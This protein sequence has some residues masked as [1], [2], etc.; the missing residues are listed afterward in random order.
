M[1][2]DVPY[3]VGH[4]KPPLHTRFPPGQSGNPKG[5]PKGRFRAA[6]V[7]VFSIPSRL[8]VKPN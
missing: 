1:D 3:A 7:E 6:R 5:R 4:K 8:N 2:Q